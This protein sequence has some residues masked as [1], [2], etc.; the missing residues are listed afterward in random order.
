MA[1]AAADS[2]RRW[3]GFACLPAAAAAVTGLAVSTNHTPTVR[4]S[5][6][7]LFS[8]F[9]IKTKQIHLKFC[10]DS[11]EERNITY[12]ELPLNPTVYMRTCLEFL[13]FEMSLYTLQ[14]IKSMNIFK[15]SVSAITL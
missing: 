5:E 1:P 13:Y 15:T 12:G 6:L 4:L 10:T 2:T 8:K 11:N 9:L 7:P 3:C 14:D